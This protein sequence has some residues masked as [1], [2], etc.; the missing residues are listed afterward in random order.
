MLEELQLRQVPCR[1]EVLFKIPYKGRIL[2]LRYRADIVCFDLVIV[3]IKACSG[4]GTVDQAQAINYL[5]VSKLRRALL[6]NFGIRSLQYR[7]VVL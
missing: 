4:L 5:K 2:P 3:E 1:Q 6:L 7:R